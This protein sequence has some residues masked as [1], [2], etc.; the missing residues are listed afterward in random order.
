MVAPSTSSKPNVPSKQVGDNEGWGPDVVTSAIG[1]SRV[2]QRDMTVKIK[3]TG[4]CL[5]NLDPTYMYVHQNILLLQ[6]FSKPKTNHV[7]KKLVTST[8]QRE[9]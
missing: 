6:S 5:N 3:V 2:A 7:Y 4:L 9:V 1:P 8:G